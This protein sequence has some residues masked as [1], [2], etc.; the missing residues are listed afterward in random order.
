MVSKT[1]YNIFRLWNA[2]RS[3]MGVMAEWGDDED[4]L[5][6]EIRTADEEI[7]NDYWQAFCE[8]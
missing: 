8:D 5:F 7:F 3:D 2:M 1:D 4:G 6:E